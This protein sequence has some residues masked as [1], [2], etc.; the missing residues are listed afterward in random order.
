MLHNSYISRDALNKASCPPPTGVGGRLRRASRYLKIIGCLL[1]GHDKNALDQ[2]F[3]DTNRSR[4]QQAGF[5][6]VEIVM[7]IVILAIISSVGITRFWGDN[8]QFTARQFADETLSA[9][10]YAQKLAVSSGCHIKA[11]F[12]ATGFTLMQRDITGCTNT[13]NAF[14][15]NVVSPSFDATSQ[16]PLPTGV[17]WRFYTID[18]DT[19]ASILI[20]PP[21]FYFD[22]LGRPI[23]TATNTPYQNQ[24]LRIDIGIELIDVFVESETGFVHL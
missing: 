6:I 18:N 1:Q 14:N 15:V 21:D 13:A 11:D 2:T 8:K 9:L 3:P 16:Y 7:V 20:G 10:R 24:V 19:G 22:N 23:D 4:Y 5:T 17:Q 12:V